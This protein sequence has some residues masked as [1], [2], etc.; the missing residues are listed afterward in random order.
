[1]ADE[2]AYSALI[3]DDEILV[4]KALDRALKKRGFITWTTSDPEAAIRFVRTHHP[5]VACIDLHMPKIN[6]I[7][8]IKR[9]REILPKIRVVAVTG[10]LDAYE[11]LLEP[12]NVRVVEKSSRTNRE[13]EN[14]LCEELELSRQ[15]FESLK[16]REKIKI[17]ARIL[18]V[19]EE[20]DVADFLQEIASEEGFEADAVY[21]GEEALAKLETFKPDIIYTDLKMK[22]MHGDELIQKLKASANHS[23]IKYYV[24]MTGEPANNSRFFQVGVKDVLNKPFAVTEFITS[25]RRYVELVNGGK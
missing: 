22:G 2:I 13:L 17:T 14:I 5:S 15:A 20:K 24:G 25:M 8:V 3:L 16:T 11:Q 18:F 4:L 9:M 10:R 12:L 7:E 6:G 1:M 23:F 21:S 19:E